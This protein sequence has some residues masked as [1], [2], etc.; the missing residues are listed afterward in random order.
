MAACFPQIKLG[1]MRSIEQFII[2]FVV[3]VF[4][5]IFNKPAEQRSLWLPENKPGANLIA[6][7]KKA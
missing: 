5:V 4:P 7:R 1:Y 3:L 6:D 2:I